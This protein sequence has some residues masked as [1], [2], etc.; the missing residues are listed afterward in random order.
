MSEQTSPL[1]LACGLAAIDP[2]RRAAHQAL[3]ARLLAEEAQ[4]TRELAAGYAFR[5]SAELLPDVALFIANERLCCPFFTFTVEVM[6]ERG[7]LW[8]HITG[9]E[10]AKDLLRS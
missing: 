10:G 6:P 8:L 2:A 5:F 7:P 3:S 4:E 1:P 9:P